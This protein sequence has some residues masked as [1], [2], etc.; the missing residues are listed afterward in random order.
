MNAERFLE[1]GFISPGAQK[2]WCK[3]QHSS[4][5]EPAPMTYACPLDFAFLALLYNYNAVHKRM[6]GEPQIFS[7]GNF[8]PGTKISIRAVGLRR[9][10]RIWRQLS[11]H[12]SE[13]NEKA[14]IS[15][16]LWERRHWFQQSTME[17]AILAFR[18]ACDPQDLSLFFVLELWSELNRARN[19]RADRLRLQ[20][21]RLWDWCTDDDEIL[22]EHSHLQFSIEVLDWAPQTLDWSRELRVLDTKQPWRNCWMDAPAEHPYNTLFAPCNPEIPL[23]V[24]TAW[25]H[26]VSL[27]KLWWIPRFSKLKSK[28]RGSPTTR[29]WMS[30]VQ[31]SLLDLVIPRP[32]LQLP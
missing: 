23:F 20:I 13:E 14:D 6:P 32:R 22:L 24:P 26:K 29:S 4:L 7:L 12:C 10:V 15:L 18:K 19:L 30:Q 2:A 8:V 25:T 9:L 28:L 5:S 16:A 31:R 21:A 27:P 1:P 3:V 17:N 11:G